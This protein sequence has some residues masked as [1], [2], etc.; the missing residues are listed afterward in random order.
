MRGTLMSVV[1][2]LLACGAAHAGLIVNGGFETGDFTGWTVTG[3][4]VLNTNYGISTINP[5]DGVYC[6]WFSGSSVCGHLHR[7]TYNPESGACEEVLP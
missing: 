1:V 3:A 6:A 5:E 7:P 2:L 4:N